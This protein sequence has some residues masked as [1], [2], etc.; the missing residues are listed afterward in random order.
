[1]PKPLPVIDVSSPICCAPIGAGP[2]AEDDAVALALRLKALA[3]P[4]R[5][6]LLSLLMGSVRGEIGAGA[7]AEAVGVSAA[8]AS[9][10]LAQLRNAG[11]VDSQ[12]RGVHVFYRAEKDNLEALRTV[13]ATCC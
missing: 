4:V 1:M 7:L 12:R 13:L 5:I 10:H 9:H 2:V 3:D 11:L 6:R 8:T